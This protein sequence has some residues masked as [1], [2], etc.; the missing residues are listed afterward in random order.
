VI[1]LTHVCRARREA[2]VSRSS[3]WV[4]FDCMN[5][6]KTLVYLERSGSSPINLSL[7]AYSEGGL[8]PHNPFLQVVPHAINRLKSLDVNGISGALQDITAHLSRPAP[9]L[10]RLSIRGGGH[11]NPQLHH[12]LP[13]AF[14]NGDLHSL[15]ELLLWS[16]R[17]ELPWRNMVNLTSFTLGRTL[18]DDIPIGRLLDFFEAAPHLR[19]VYL[20]AATPISG[21]QDGRLVILACL[22][23][24]GISGNEPPSL[25]LNYLIIPVG[26]KLTTKYGHQIDGHLPKSLDNLRNL[27]DFTWVLLCANKYSPRMR[28]GGPN[29]QVSIIPMCAQSDTTRLVLESLARLDTSK[30]Q[31]LRIHCGNSPSIIPPYRALLPMKD[32]RTLMLSRCTSPDI[33]LHTLDPRMNSRGFVICPKL[34]ELVLILRKN[35]ET[36]NI[37][38]V[39]GVA[40]AR[41]SRGAKLGSVRIVT[42]DK[43]MQIDALELK[44]HVS[45]VE[46]GPGAGVTDDYSDDGDAEYDY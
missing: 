7:H 36:L 45:H 26:A 5:M 34:Q 29:G 18:P 3:L 21:A 22:E 9:L 25:L 20:S 33:F 12:V 31:W 40:A 2:F 32:L 10:E 16:V 1:A 39:T 13:T 37:R 43:S 28:F 15:R 30:T 41:A 38:S 8:S 23:K 17:T 4:D 24:I 35:R 42:H 6:D 27:S 46:C 19:D 14:L 44:E 11:S